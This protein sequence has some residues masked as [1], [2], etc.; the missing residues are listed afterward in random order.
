MHPLDRFRETRL[1]PVIAGLAIL[2]VALFILHIASILPPFIWAAVTAYLAHP[3]VKRIQRATRLPRGVVIGVLYIV[4][5]GLLIFVAVQ[6]VPT[7]YAQTRALVTS[8][9][10]LINTA[11]EELLREPQI[12]I[13]GITIDTREL[14]IQATQIAQQIATRFGQE[15]VPLVLYTV[16]LLIKMLVYLLTTFYLLLQGDD[17]INGIQKLAP[18]RHQGT[19]GRIIQRVNGTFGAYIRAQLALFAIV[20]FTTFI[21]LSVLKVEYALALAIA[22]G[23]LELIPIIGPWVA[24]G[25]AILVGLSQGTTPFNWSPVQLAAVIGIAYF[26]LRMAQDHLIIPQLVGRVVRLHPILVIFGLLVGSTTGG[27]LGLLLAVPTLAALK[28]IILE[29]IQELR[30][31]PARRVVL[32]QE[33][34]TLQ[35]FRDGVWEYHH[36]HVVL[37]IAEEAVSWDDLELVEELADVAIRNDTRI[38]V[39]TPD[40]VAASIATAAG[41]EVIT[42]DRLNGEERTGEEPVEP[43]R[44]PA[45]R[46]ARLRAGHTIKLGPE[47]QEEHVR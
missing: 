6:V 34:G 1:L 5:I 7:L 11:R 26:A 35:E 9:P 47:A 46:R 32:L 40:P 19:V 18:R 45:K 42:R 16:G 31:P 3:L 2:A 23:I 4:F 33:P 12:R 37:L 44:E 20:S 8:L 29:V 21:T 41:I 10:Q 15:A 43:G 36:Q 39:V 25:S 14:S 13:G 22:T 38:Q 24:A 28:I 17:L 27:I 30:H